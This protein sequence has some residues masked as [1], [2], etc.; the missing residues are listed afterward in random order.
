MI[1]FSIIE[2]LGW[3]NFCSEGLA[4][5][6]LLLLE[7]VFCNL[8]LLFVMVEDSRH[9]LPLV[10]GCCIMEAPEHFQQS[11]ITG[12]CGIILQLYCLGVIS[13]IL[14]SRVLGGSSRV[15]DAGADHPRGTAILRLGEP[16]S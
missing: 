11:V 10:A 5:F 4:N 3:Q 6:V 15:P 1:V 7:A 12:S 9:V 16:E 14:V 2:C 8:L 13:Q